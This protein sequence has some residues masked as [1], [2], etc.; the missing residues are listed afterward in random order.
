MITYKGK[1]GSAN[2]MIDE[3]DEAT[4]SQIHS[5]LNHPAFGHTYIAIMPDCH[6]G[7]G[8]CIGLT[9]K[10][11]DYIIP[12]VVGVDIGCGV[13]A[14]NLGCV[15]IDYA[16]LDAFI[17]ENIPS[18]F[19]LRNQRTENVRELMKGEELGQKIR[20]VVWDTNQD[21]QKVER[22]LGTLGGGNHFI[23]IDYHEDTGDYWLLI[24][25]GSRNFGLR[26]AQFYQDKAKELLKKMFMGADA[27]KGLEYLPMDMGG[28]EYL[29]AM[30]V[31]QEYAQFNRFEMV[32]ILMNGFFTFGGWR[33]TI[34]TVHNYINF[35]DNI[36]RKGAVAAHEGQRLVIPFN[37]RDGVAMCTGKGSSKWNYSAPH[38]AGRV[39]SRSQA[40]KELDLADFQESMEGI[41][42][43]TATKNTIDEAP[44]AYKDM[45]KIIEAIGETVEIDF[46]MKPVYNFKAGGD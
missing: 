23:E 27:Y 29:E 16:A 18:G 9:M 8:S 42:T 37:M 4:A 6:K 17:K 2:V 39:M 33:E 3:V 12:N 7:A 40:K 15:E 32:D 5:F 25:S 44:M 43:T 1:H 24:H 10:T 11:N 34:E 36:I 38:G 13:L 26:V 41:Y 46:M 30:K 22:S 14:I 35:E 21:M 31:A 20:D 19:S 28:A 45:D